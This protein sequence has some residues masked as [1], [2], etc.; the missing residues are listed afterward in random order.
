MRKTFML[1]AALALGSSLVAGPADAQFRWPWEKRDK[2]P[3]PAP[4]AAPTAAPQPAPQG[5]Q[6]QGA[7]LP[8]EHAF[9]QTLHE[10]NLK[11][12]ALGE[13]AL[14]KAQDAGVKSFAQML[15]DDHRR[16]D[17]ML[18]AHVQR[19]GWSLQGA[20]SPA[21]RPDRVAGIRIPGTARE[22]SAPSAVANDP[23]LARLEGLSGESF[24]RAFLEANIA[25]HDAILPQVHEYKKKES[26]RAFHDQLQTMFDSM[27]RH[28]EQAKA[29]LDQS[30][31][32]Q[33]VRGGDDK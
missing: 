24:D 5:Q 4:T 23:D 31:G 3:N 11:E 2:K 16:G 7:A 27:K 30:Y 29:L 15:V 26:D 12:I 19:M 13:L 25:A 1:A 18:T 32:R 33:N 20:S 8:Q 21:S 9:L 14:R 28:R 10:N 17:E 22:G 6:P